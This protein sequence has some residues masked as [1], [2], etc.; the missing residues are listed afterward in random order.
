M[1]ETDPIRVYVTHLFKEDT[2]YLR[3]F[4]YRESRDKFF[5]INCSEPEAVPGAGGIEAIKETL[6]KQIEKSEVLILPVPGV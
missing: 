3:V 2:D 1:S 4:E 6:R 5:Y